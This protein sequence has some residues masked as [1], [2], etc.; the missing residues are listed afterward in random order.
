MEAKKQT[1]GKD[2]EMDMQTDRQAK[3]DKYGCI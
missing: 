3:G 2:V 1:V